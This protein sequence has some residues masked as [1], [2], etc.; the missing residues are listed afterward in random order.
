MTD[1]LK[2]N[3][4]AR[5]LSGRMLKYTIL[6]IKKSGQSFEFQS[7]TIPT[8]KFCDETRTPVLFYGEYERQPLCNW[9]DVELLIH[10]ANP[11]AEEKNT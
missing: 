6:L 10:E 2:A 7:D 8:M 11:D 9:E 4:M 3:K 1:T 5:L